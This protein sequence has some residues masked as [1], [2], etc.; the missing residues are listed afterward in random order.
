LEWSVAQ[1]HV[2]VFVQELQL[3]CTVVPHSLAGTFSELP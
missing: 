2:I 1:W 3:P